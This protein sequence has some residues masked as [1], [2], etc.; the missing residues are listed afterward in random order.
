[1]SGLGSSGSTEVDPT[2]AYFHALFARLEIEWCVAGAVAANAYRSPRDTTDL[3]LVVQIEASRYSAVAEALRAGGWRLLRVS[4]GGDYP[5]VVR[6]EHDEF[7]PTDLLLVKTAYQA[8]AL[9]RARILPPG[10]T[11]ILAPEDVLIHKLIAYRHRD[12]ADIAEILR[13]GTPLDRSYVEHW[14]REWE[15]LERWRDALGESEG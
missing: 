8:E 11:R 10:S 14:S 9:R 1:M 4:P 3:D 15:V 6:L 12:R 5:D 2:L 7:F 13:S